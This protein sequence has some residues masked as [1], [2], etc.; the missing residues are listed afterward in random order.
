MRMC[1]C[2]CV[3]CAVRGSE[4]HTY[5]TNIHA[6][7]ATLNIR[8]CAKCLYWFTVVAFMCLLGLFRKWKIKWKTLTPR[9][10]DTHLRFTARNSVQFEKLENYSHFTHV[11]FWFWGGPTSMMDI[12]KWQA[13][14]RHLDGFYCLPPSS[15]PTLITA[16]ICNLRRKRHIAYRLTLNPSKFSVLSS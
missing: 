10:W 16:L 14:S 11:R 4:F 2:L 6:Q 5:D 8:W 7:R 3:L 9:F 1:V 12:G 13:H 15:L